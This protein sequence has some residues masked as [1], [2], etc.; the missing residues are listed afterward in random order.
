MG[1]VYVLTSPSGKQYVGMTQ[2]DIEV[3]WSQHRRLQS[4]RPI[5]RAI[6]KYG[7][8]TFK[9][10]IVFQSDD[11]CALVAKEIELIAKLRCMVPAGYNCTAG[12]EGITRAKRPPHVIEA[13]KRA[14]IGKVV[15]E[16]TRAKLRAAHANG[17]P[18]NSFT[19]RTHSEETR[20]RLSECK[21]GF[22]HSE[23]T[24]AAMSERMRQRWAER[25]AS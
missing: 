14:H 12:G 17:K 18:R 7:W 8:D 13:I 20:R 24:R 9:R 23:A 16:E 19:G 2:R 25:R 21:K 22:R 5:N 6:Q 15:S 11:K 4:G 1:A 10:E 3:R